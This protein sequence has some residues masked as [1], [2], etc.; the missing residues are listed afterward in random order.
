MSLYSSE[1]AVQSLV[2]TVG[3]RS[4]SQVATVLSYIVLVRG[5]AE[6]DFGVYNLL[7]ALLPVI[8]T[9][10][11]LGIE[12]TLRRFQPEY[13]KSGNLAAAAWLHRI[14]AR[15]RL[16]TNVTLIIILL[17]AWGWVA[18][19][20]GLSGYRVDFAIFGIMV[21]LHFQSRVLQF[22][23]ASHMLHQYSMG[24][25]TVMSFVKLAAYAALAA[26]DELNLRTAIFSDILAYVGAFACMYVGYYR[27]CRA[28]A[29]T[30]KWRP[31]GDE[32]GRLTR[33]AVYN[34]FNDAGSVFSFAQIDNFFIAAF[35]SPAVVAI[36]AFYTRLRAM[37]GHLV[38]VRLF[39]NIVQPMFFAVSREDAA[40]RIPKYFT[41]LVNTSLAVFVPMFAYAVAYH[42]ELIRVVFGGKY[43]ADSQLLPMVLAL[44]IPGVLSTPITLVAQ[45]EERAS[46]VLA[47][48]AF[49]LYL[50]A[51]MAILIPIWG[52]YG[53]ALAA[54]SFHLVR[55]AF[56][57]WRVRRLAR[58]LDATKSIA[59]QIVIWT[60]AIAVC[61][62]LKSLIGGRDMVNLVIGAVVCG[63]GLLLHV[64]SPALCETDRVILTGAVRGR[65]LRILGW[66]G[67]RQ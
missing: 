26:V 35:L 58:W 40:E 6:H 1:R 7:Q 21:L 60:V 15:T 44:A 63:A 67:L 33:Y 28:P 65:N 62:G 25:V 61:L 8:S 5:I 30:P 43:V 51:A 27:H 4:A 55:N 37:L 22:T 59:S 10:A 49:A 3:F 66:L 18:P 54:G 16:F 47:S 13:L 45:F 50:V 11:S 52:I 36:Y 17:L 9:T 29:G 31:D 24:S 14:S 32:R 42:A 20:F 53:A 39:E 56:V 48:Q 38:P 12:Q 64:R 2:H 46:L 23:L 41:F 57:W 19:I 34:N